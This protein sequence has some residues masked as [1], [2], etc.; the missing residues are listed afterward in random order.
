[1]LWKFDSMNFNPY[2]SISAPIGVPYASMSAP[3]GVP[4]GTSS[5]PV[6]SHPAHY[7]T[8]SYPS[9]GVCVRERV[10]VC[11]PLKGAPCANSLCGLKRLVC[12]CVF[13]CV[14]VCTLPRCAHSK[15]AGGLQRTTGFPTGLNEM[16]YPAPPYG[17]ETR[18]HRC[19][20]FDML[21]VGTTTKH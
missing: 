10:Y 5:L 2:A 11:V 3:I 19:L 12:V 16:P 7:G 20:S 18:I 17:N 4:W 9:G 14:C 1:M 13:V 8:V 6:L 21:I 15:W